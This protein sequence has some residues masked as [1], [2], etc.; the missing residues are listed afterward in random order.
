MTD[1]SPAPTQAQSST[2][3]RLEAFS[4][5]VIAIAITLL[6]LEIGIPAVQRTHSLIDALA[7]QWPSYV[8]F[9]ISFVVIGIM[10]VS[11]HAMFER[12]ASVDR[13]MLFLNLM[14]LMGIAFLPFPTA[15]LAEYVRE[16]GQNASVAAAIY[17]ATM[18]LIGLAFAAMWRHL[19]RN[20][21]LLVG[22]ISRDRIELAIRRSMV[23]PV[24]YTASIGLAFISAPACFVVYAL[25]AIY[26]GSNP[27][28]RVATPQAPVDAGDVT[29]ET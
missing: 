18:A 29:S 14:L 26:F 4:D 23:G 10:W 21:H 13:G 19:L 22:G 20:P 28:S 25:V 2:T 16:G 8:A 9:L 6:V 5:G 3:A 11:H 17:S 27:S 1:P 15:L 24:V 7:E 12:I